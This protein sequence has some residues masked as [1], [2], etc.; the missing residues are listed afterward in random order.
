MSLNIAA[1]VTGNSKADQTDHSQS[2]HCL[3]GLLCFFFAATLPS[4]VSKQVQNMFACKRIS[5][6]S[7]EQVH[8]YTFDQLDNQ[9]H[10]KTDRQTDRQVSCKPTAR[11]AA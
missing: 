3:S 2:E 7:F 1:D 9:T 11:P 4:V 5:S 8:M 6:L 10:R